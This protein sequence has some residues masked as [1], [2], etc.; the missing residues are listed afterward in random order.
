MSRIQALSNEISEIRT[1]VA[2]IERSATEANRDL[3]DAEQADTD[4]L[5][6][7]ATTINTAITAEVTKVE[8]LNESASLLARL[9]GHEAPAQINRA[10]VELTAGEFLSAAL[11]A[12]A[13]MDSELVQRA[14]Q[15]L[16]DN[17]G[18]VPTPIVGSLISLYDASRPVWNSFTSQP[19]P[20]AGKSFTR[21]KVTQHVATGN[22]AAEFDAVST[23]KMII[24]GS[25]V[26]KFTEAGY[27]DLSQQDIDWTDPA[28]LQ[29]VVQDFA[30]VYSNRM[31]ARACSFLVTTASASAAWT[32]TNVSTI[33]SSVT[34]GVQAVYNTA[35]SMPDTL[36]L[37]LDEALSL[38]GTV[39]GDYNRTA[40]AMVNEALAAAGVNVNVVVGPQL[41]SDTRILGVSR[42]IESYENINGL[43]QVA[44]PDILGQRIAYSG[45]GA[46]FGDSAGFVKL[47]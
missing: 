6:E 33:V 24:T 46:L 32:A 23:Q 15:V 3:T 4:T 41:A 34:S 40:M 37:S 19:L 8:K 28:A 29:L 22:Q 38:A 35:K 1:A 44:Q 30:D 10:A 16:A 26:N 21:P 18:I 31:E 11:Q 5:L 45:Y 47:V 9:N 14:Q 20:A 43:L 7:R 17:T 36:W 13:G 12:Q 39:T 42:L 27:L 2:N 25:T